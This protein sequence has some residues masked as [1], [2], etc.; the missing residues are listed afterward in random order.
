MEEKQTVLIDGDAIA[1]LSARVDELLDAQN[2]ADMEGFIGTFD[3]FTPVFEYDFREAQFHYI[4]GNAHSL[5]YVPQL[6]EWYD[7]N[8]NKV[9]IHFKKALNALKNS[10]VDDEY[11]ITLKSKIETNYGNY[12][13]QQ[14]RFMCAKRHWKNAIDLDNQPIAHTAMYDNELYLSRYTLYDEPKAIYHQFLAYKSLC[15]RMKLPNNQARFNDSDYIFDDN[16]TQDFK[17]WF[18]EQYTLDHFNHFY[19][20]NDKEMSKK[21][22]AY[23]NWCGTNNLFIDDLEIDEHPEV[24]R[25]DSLSLPSFSCR[26]NMTLA[27]HEDLV[28]HANFDEIKSDFCYARYLIFSASNIS[29]ETVNFFNNTFTKTDD[30]THTIDN[31]K[32]QQ[33]KSAFKILY[34]LFD[35]IAYFISHFYDLNDIDNDK[36]INF[37]NLFKRRRS[38]EWKPHDKLKESTNQFIHAL[39]YILKDLRDIKDQ[40]SVSDWLNPEL[41]KIYEIRNYIEHRSFK[42]IDSLYEDI[43]FADLVQRNEIEHLNNNKEQYNDE[44]QALYTEIK[45]YKYTEKHQSLINKKEQLEEWIALIDE[46]LYEKEK[47]SKHTLIMTEKDFTTQLMT[48]AELVRN[49]IIYLSFSIEFEEHTKR[50]NDE[51]LVWHR[52]VPRK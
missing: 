11:Q 39:F 37:E 6:N 30:L 47:R 1:L 17:L 21:E 34:A 40:E 27:Y 41:V 3:V 10:N 19:K 7:P 15:E 26:L 43:V 42:I 44:L 35:K 18:E 48:L 28:Y 5:L 24:I 25:P 4:L 46:Q 33:L 8:L 14:G 16:R 20:K 50:K 23:L 32:A 22:I 52:E 38:N 9:I 29:N 2:V 45:A 13:S 31:I 12:L 49:S 36:Q 51:N